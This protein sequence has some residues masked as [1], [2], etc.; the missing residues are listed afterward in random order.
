MVYDKSGHEISTV[1]DAHGSETV[2]YDIHGNELGG[3]A[4]FLDAF[5]YAKRKSDDDD[6][7]HLFVHTDQ[8]GTLF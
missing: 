8:H 2:P 1:Y 5:K 6:G 4:T 7:I 3:F